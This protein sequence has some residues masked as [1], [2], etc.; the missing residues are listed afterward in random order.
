MTK[1]PAECV[2]LLL[3]QNKLDSEERRLLRLES[4][5]SKSVNAYRFS[6][7]GEQHD[8]FF[9]QGKPWTM[10]HW[11]CDAEFFYW[12]HSEDKKQRMLICCNVTYVEAGGRRIVSSK[13]AL[14]RCEIIEDE[15][16]V[17]VVSSDKDVT[18]DKEA[19][20]MIDAGADSQLMDSSTKS[21]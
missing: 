3:P 12:M 1:L 2:T 5:A 6:T 8:F 7:A 9:G 14:L 16:Q 11:K 13:R 19:F 18:V 21:S 15:G 10:G 17:R 4:S 20:A